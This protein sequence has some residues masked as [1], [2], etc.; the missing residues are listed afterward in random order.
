MTVCLG[1]R[2]GK[3]APESYHAFGDVSRLSLL[4]IFSQGLKGG[5]TGLESVMYNPARYNKC[6]SL[7][8]LNIEKYTKIIHSN[9]Q[10]SSNH[11]LCSVQHKMIV[12]CLLLRSV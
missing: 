2:F 12:N 9:Q 10:T 8:W 6:L 5:P 1:D 11:M 3:N 7:Y 4:F